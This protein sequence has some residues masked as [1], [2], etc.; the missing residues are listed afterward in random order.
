MRIVKVFIDIHDLIIKIIDTFSHLLN[1]LFAFNQIIL[2]QQ[3][4][5]F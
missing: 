2:F 5:P 3:K 4:E 1:K